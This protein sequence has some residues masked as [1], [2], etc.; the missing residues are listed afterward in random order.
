MHDSLHRSN[1]EI[2]RLHALLAETQKAQAGRALIDSKQSSVLL[3]KDVETQLEI[4][5]R[6]LLI[7][8]NKLEAANVDLMKN[9]VEIE[10][11]R[12]ELA[13]S[14]GDV[15][16]LTLEFA[17]KL[18]RHQIEL[19]E[20]MKSV[21]SPV[22][23]DKTLLY[24][25][26]KE[27]EEA[28]RA[29]VAERVANDLIVG[30]LSTADT[31]NL[32][33]RVFTDVNKD[34]KDN[35]LCL[36]ES[37]EQVLQLTEELQT[38]RS[39][40]DE[41]I[42]ICSSVELMEEELSSSRR[43][44]ET[45][46][47]ASYSAKKDSTSRSNKFKMVQIEY[48][49]TI[50]KLTIDLERVQHEYA[51][52]QQDYTTQQDEIAAMESEL[53]NVNFAASIATEEL[54]RLRPLL[55]DAQEQLLARKS[56]EENSELLRAKESLSDQSKEVQELNSLLKDQ[57]TDLSQQ[58]HECQYKLGTTTSALTSKVDE[59]NSLNQSLAELKAACKS[60]EQDRDE[61]R[62]SYD[63]KVND[64]VQYQIDLTT[65]KSS[66]E[67]LKLQNEKLHSHQKTLQQQVSKLENDCRN[68]AEVISDLN[69]QV[70]GSC[71][72]LIE[73]KQEMS[74][75]LVSLD[76]MKLIVSGKDSCLSEALSS[77]SNLTQQEKNLQLEIRDARD[78]LMKANS[79]F[80]YVSAQ[81]DSLTDEC[82][83][84]KD[85]IKLVNKTNATLEES[86]SVTKA[87]LD[88]LIQSIQRLEMER[89]ALADEVEELKACKSA[90]TLDN[91]NESYGLC[92]SVDDSE[93]EI[94]AARAE[95]TK[96]QDVIQNFE[97]KVSTLEARFDESEEE[98]AVATSLSKIFEE[99]MKASEL[100]KV[101]TEQMLVSSQDDAAKLRAELKDTQEKFEQKNELHALLLDNSYL[102][103]Q[104][105][106]V[107]GD[108]DLTKN[109]MTMESSKLQTSEE[110]NSKLRAESAS[111][112]CQMEVYVRE[113][114]ELR[115]LLA[116]SESHGKSISYEAE[117]MTAMEAQYRE[118]LKE[119]S[120]LQG[121]LAT[122]Q[123]QL[124]ETDKKIEKCDTR[125]DQLESEKLEL[126]EK[127]LQ[128]QELHEDSLQELKTEL[129]DLQ[130]RFD[131]QSELLRKGNDL[132]TS[133]RIE[134]TSSREAA[135][136]SSNVVSELRAQLLESQETV[137]SLETGMSSLRLKEADIKRELKECRNDQLTC[138]QDLS[139]TVQLL[140]VE[141]NQNELNNT[142]IRG[143]EC[144]L[145]KTLSIVKRQ[146]E[147]KASSLLPTQLHRLQAL[148][149]ETQSQ[150]VLR[151]RSLTES[152]RTIEKLLKSNEKLQLELNTSK[153]NTLNGVESL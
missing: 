109:A 27:L 101:E 98:R 134:L 123:K 73:K 127:L 89:D 26:A 144:E 44:I 96:S 145:T 37:K 106:K 8:E 87:K 83:I 149:E 152:Q 126:E 118:L 104:L 66:C 33:T 111:M 102:R 103:E 19:T 13:S 131:D 86:L 139:H 72:A 38:L 82:A 91:C 61:L 94:T 6:D 63:E 5:C 17:D 124:L 29:L 25:L 70:R 108:L 9:R 140:E 30:E 117:N 31:T 34:P 60:I 56:V 55:Q 42:A 62:K 35:H 39:K 112:T 130:R 135:D 114:A 121:D 143:L 74:R 14:R 23:I 132:V 47:A 77:L 36:A 57:I 153:E 2:D 16:T 28:L 90:Y 49:K 50:E 79:D 142:K 105:S 151:D 110:A 75:L 81:R 15:A 71:D 10:S 24:T 41:L 65:T 18:S 80:A 52:L 67:N 85:Q 76:E 92:K 141:R 40:Y 128:N 22:H 146:S 107:T 78:A 59:V 69:F 147:S 11:L 122:A 45:L 20:M 150:L 116:Q 21:G 120:Q 54:D 148:L 51:S 133:M 58:L 113:I 88:P 125:R 99:R 97:S 100:N 4:K 53:S 43:L 32:R 136:V 93:G 64:V 138:K 1:A 115:E 12:A 84:Q 95:L 46:K 137:K 119:L 48:Q 129:L 68:S 3:L 7:A